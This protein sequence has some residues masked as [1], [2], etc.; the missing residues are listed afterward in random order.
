MLDDEVRI[1][2]ATTE[3]AEELSDI[4][5]QSKEYWDLDNDELN[6]FREILEISPELIENNV[7]YVAENIETEEILGFYFIENAEENYLLR[8]LCVAP[9]YM[10]TGIGEALFLSACEMAEE[11]GAEELQILC[12]KNSQEFYMNMGA[13]E[14]G[15]F[16]I[17]ING[18]TVYCLKLQM[19]LN[20]D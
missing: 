3:D 9:D 12:D 6:E 15:E 11:I 14:L 20:S 4:A 13:K 19:T 18:R 8:Y 10:G 17:Q 2:P 1:R 7:A 16:P 5:W